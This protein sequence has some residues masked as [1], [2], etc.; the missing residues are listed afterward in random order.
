MELDFSHV[1]EVQDFLSVPPGNYLCRVAEV[2]EGWTRSGDS[3]WSI[4]LEVNEG[5]FAGKTA[6]WDFVSFG[7]RG[8]RRAKFVLAALGFPTDGKL[9][10]EPEDLVGRLAR[11]EVLAEERVDEQTGARQVRPRVP[12]EGYALVQPF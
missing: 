11:V 8:A 3:R 5:E 4:R 10:I 12:F 9:S 1:E 7:E 2:R 6:A